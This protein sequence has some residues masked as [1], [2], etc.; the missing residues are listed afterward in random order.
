M[1]GEKGFRGDEVAVIELYLVLLI[2]FEHLNFSS[3]MRLVKDSS[4]DCV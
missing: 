2:T 4:V 1:K 3:L